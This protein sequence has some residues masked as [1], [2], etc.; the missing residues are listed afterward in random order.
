VYSVTI[1]FVIADKQLWEEVQACLQDMPMQVV[2]EQT[3]IDEWTGFAEKLD[4][5]RPSVLLLD[6]SALSEPAEDV[7]RR[8][9]ALASA[10][11]VVALHT[12]A[13]PEVI[14]GAIRAGAQEFLY[15]PLQTNLPKAFERIAADRAM[16]DDRQRQGGRT[17]GFLSAKGGCGATTIACHVAAELGRLGRGRVLL[18]DF[19]FESGMLGF[20]TK[21][22]SAYSIMDALANLNRLDSAFWKKLVSNGRPGLEIITAPS[23]APRESPGHD[24]VHKI[25]RF[26][27][28][29]YDWSILDLGRG[30]TPLSMASL[31][32]VEQAFLV[33]TLDV[34]ALHQAKRVIGKLLDS[35]Y[36]REKL[37]IILNR[38][39]RN[40]DVTPSEVERA[41]G[42]SVHAAIPNDYPALYE[43]YSEGK[44]L[45]E[46]AR[47]R[48][49]FTEIAL[50][51]AG[52]ET[53][54]KSRK[55]K[56]SLFG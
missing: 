31:G 11:A 23:S 42:I 34:P 27:R 49:T 50:K 47:L 40:P 43:A 52:A 6:L 2:L 3:R 26:L 48:R 22:E 51:L 16:H 56:F 54:E 9:R 30:L 20:L 41:L 55:K 21:S 28:V 7:I 39:P 24:S 13:D 46:T 4:R 53:E 8:I 33:A 29:E 1:G 12:V 25:L 32:S 18:A 45:G 19:D 37:S 10:P 36:P 14:L 17:L 35:G 44:L 5:V 38:V 15:P